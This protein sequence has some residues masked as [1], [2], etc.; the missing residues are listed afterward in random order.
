MSFDQNYG[1]GSSNAALNQTLFLVSD[2]GLKSNSSQVLLVTD[3]NTIQGSSGPTLLRMAPDTVMQMNPGFGSIIPNG[4]QY[5]NGLGT[6]EMAPSSLYVGTSDQLILCLQ[7]EQLATLHLPSASVSQATILVQESPGF[8]SLESVALS[9]MAK[10]WQAD[11][12]LVNRALMA[13]SSHQT[14][15]S[16]SNPPPIENLHLS[17]SS[18][19]L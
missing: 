7:P 18:G 17:H 11:A 19:H 8:E 15:T 3:L 13:L 12:E 2:D 14:P 1:A 6:V 5:Q 4:V 16:N 9:Q 10:S